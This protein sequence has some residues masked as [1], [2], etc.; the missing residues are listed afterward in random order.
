MGR[1]EEVLL[2]ATKVEKGRVGGELI[3]GIPPQKAKN[4][5]FGDP[6]HRRDR[7]AKSTP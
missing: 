7:E 6:G 1:I 3:A 5:L 4:G 2:F